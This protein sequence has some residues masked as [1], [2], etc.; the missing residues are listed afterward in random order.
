MK[1]KHITIIASIDHFFFQIHYGQTFPLTTLR[2]I[3]PMIILQL[4]VS[5]TKNQ[6][7]SHILFVLHKFYLKLHNAYN[8]YVDCSLFSKCYCIISGGN[9]S[10]TKCNATFILKLMTY[11]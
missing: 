7:S 4:Q 11:I 2:Q 5:Q 1:A 6:K 9:S 10:Q 3:L 8:K